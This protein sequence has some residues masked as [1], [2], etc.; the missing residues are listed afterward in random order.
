MA[1]V[2]D[3]LIQLNA[4]LDENNKKLDTHITKLE[5][6][7]VA[8]ANFNAQLSKF[9]S[10]YK[11]KLEVVR[12]TLDEV[13]QSNQDLLK[14]EKERIKL[15]QKLI[16]LSTDQAKKA[17]TLKVEIQERNKQLKEEAKE[18]LGLVN[19]YDK[20]SKR[21][22]E[23]RSH[24]KNL[25]VQEGK[26]TK[27]TEALKKEIQKLDRELKEVDADVGQFQRNVGNYAKAMG[28]AGSIVK[29]AFTGGLIGSAI[30]AASSKASEFF[31]L[32]KEAGDN[33]KTN[34]APVLASLQVLLA[35]LVDIIPV[36]IKDLQVFFKEIRLGIAELPEALGGSKEKAAE[37][38][39][40]IK[41]LND[42]FKGKSY[43]E[44]FKDFGKRI[45]E[46]TAQLREN[47]EINRQA[48]LNM[49]KYTR[50]IA[51]LTAQEEALRIIADDNNRSFEERAQAFQEARDIADKRAK[52]E[53][54]LAKEQL[55][56]AESQVALQLK[57]AGV[58]ADLTNIL[59]DKNKASK[60]DEETLAK[61][62]EALNGVIE[63]EGRRSQQLKQ[64]AKEAADI[65]RD[66]FEQN[67]DYALDYTD[68][69]KAINERLIADDRLTL[70]ARKRILAE[71]NVIFQ[72]A[73]E[74]QVA[75]FEEQ[76]GKKIDIGALITAEDSGTLLETVRALQM[77]E[78]ETQRLLEVIR[79][80][81]T[82][83]QDLNEAQRDLNLTE[84]ETI[85]LQTEIALQ[86]QYL[87]GEIKTQ[88]EYDTQLTRAMIANMQERLA[89]MEEGSIEYLTTLKEINDALINLKDDEEGLGD[90]LKQFKQGFIDDF[91]NE[92]GFDKLFF[93]I[94]NF[95]KLKESGVDTALAI[96]EAFQ[97][98]FNTIAEASMANFDREYERLEMQKEIAIE[99]A[100]ESASAQEE[101]ERQYEERKKQIQ[102]REAEAQKK[103]AIFNI[104]LNTAQ[105][106]TA[107]LASTPPNIPLSV[108]IGVIGA[109]QIAMVASKEIP[110]FWR[111]TDN[112]PEGWAYTQERGAEIITDKHG[113][114]KTLGNDGGAKLTYLN[115]GD[116]VYTAEKSKAYLNDILAK[117]GILPIGSAFPQMQIV[118]NG[119][120]KEDLNEN[121]NNLARVIRGKENININIDK[122]GFR[123]HIGD[124]EVVNNR[125]TGKSRSV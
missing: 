107:A 113:N 112:A 123:T 104:A 74:Q 103:L 80:Y 35:S 34:L 122:R 26:A 14:T 83:V 4:V 20:K 94:E 115:K 3:N 114:V 91:I 119:I 52:A 12:N 98:A 125:L 99:F 13:E 30:G 78:I 110:Q 25:I 61:Y 56:L 111:G 38:K 55:S 19:A 46:T 116:K 60:V 41:E 69:Q 79:D 1:S 44:A 66:L 42:N 36:L 40:E 109:A 82:G 76:T 27:E 96:S 105:G 62:V 81:K 90:W 85:D 95:D 53:I 117:N 50:T 31:T 64:D 11:Q 121:F 75:L 92:S 86:M 84:Q 5:A 71:T 97:Q 65:T 8:A 77:G 47:V 21:L 24:Y 118:N 49:L 17:A 43:S 58:S 89:T 7:A 68:N 16:E 22:N 54:A 32:S 70:D 15:E 10:D 33:A 57:Q 29:S 23:L 108:A 73:L 93:L 39:K 45:E 51:I 28:N 124:K 63:A 18:E 9:P 2:K 6:G 120:T 87:N 100:G 67:L 88:E 48:E 72:K 59:N 106:I 102:R 37:L 101:I